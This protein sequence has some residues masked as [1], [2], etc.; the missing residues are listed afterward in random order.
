MKEI[1]ALADAQTRVAN[2]DMKS[3]F[4]ELIFISVPYLFVAIFGYSDS[5]INSFLLKGGM[6]LTIWDMAGE[7]K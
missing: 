7:L 5:I 1:K 6:R 3:L 4:H 2:T